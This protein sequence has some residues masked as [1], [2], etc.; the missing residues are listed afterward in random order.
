M[1]AR[2]AKFQKPTVPSVF[3][4]YCSEVGFPNGCG[5]GGEKEKEEVK[6]IRTLSQYFQKNP[7]I[8]PKHTTIGSLGVFRHRSE[9]KHVSVLVI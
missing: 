9:M 3:N 4:R 6:G 7:A 2:L 8:E 1:K 5:P